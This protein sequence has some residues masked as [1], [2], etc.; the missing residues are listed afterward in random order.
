VQRQEKKQIP[1]GNDRKK[2]KRNGGSEGK[3]NGGSEGKRNGRSEGKR[4]GRSEGKS[5]GGV[6][7]SL[8]CASVEMTMV[9]AFG[10]TREAARH[11]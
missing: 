5:N 11:G 4:N 2:G 9:W 6:H 3:R 8:R 1:R 7:G 10:K